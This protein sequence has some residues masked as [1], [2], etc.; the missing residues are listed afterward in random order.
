[1]ENRPVTGVIKVPVRGSSELSQGQVGLERLGGGGGGIP[2][3]WLE[4]ELE[5]LS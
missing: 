2:K 4:V 1:M 5:F 3:D